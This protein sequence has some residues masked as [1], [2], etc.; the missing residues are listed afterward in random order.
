MNF[1]DYWDE[2]FERLSK[3]HLQSQ[4]A[5]YKGKVHL[6]TIEEWGD[7]L[8]GKTVLKT[9]LFEECFGS[10]HLLDRLDSN[11]KVGIDISKRIVTTAR[12]RVGDFKGIVTRIQ[13]L[14]FS[15]QSFDVIISNSTLDHLRREEVPKSLK[16]LNRVL[17]DDGTSIL[18][19][20]NKQNPLYAIGMAIG[21]KTGFLPFYQDKCYS[22]GELEC[23]LTEAGFNT[24]EASAIFHVPPPVSHL[25]TLIEE[26]SPL[27][28]SKIAEEAIKLAERIH[29]KKTKLI[30][31]R[32]LSFN[33]KK[34]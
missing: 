3:S 14:P 31:G 6:R 16:E 23:L 22:V 34:A 30:S 4:I 15:D 10:D 8:S 13:N 33:V 2:V 21:Q 29:D 9:D 1:P 24:V 26:G 27:L 17:K 7:D 25:I 19:M 18:T 12:G 20:D 32:L 28:A 11:N 5:K